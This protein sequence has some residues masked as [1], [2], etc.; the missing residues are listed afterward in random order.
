M[1]RVTLTT[2]ASKLGWLPA[3]AL[4]AYAFIACATGD[5]NA[6]TDNGDAVVTPT[7]AHFDGAKTDGGGESGACTPSAPT[8]C[9]TPTDLGTVTLGQTITASATIAPTAN[10]AWFKVTFDKLADLSAHPHITLDSAAASLLWLEVARDCSGAHL[11][12]SQEGSQSATITEFESTY[13]VPDAGDAGE[14]GDDGAVDPGADPDAGDAFMPLSFGAG[15]VAYVRAF[16]KA[17]APGPCAPL[18]LTISN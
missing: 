6:P 8:T 16:R 5:Q 4:L 3:G 9:A 1:A 10:D 17:G 2:V 15:G 12:C 7:D 11:A 18:Q 13:A 14:A